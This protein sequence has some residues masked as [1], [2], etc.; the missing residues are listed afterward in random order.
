MPTFNIIATAT[1]TS[2]PATI[3]FSSIPSTYTDLC[4]LLC[5]RG[6]YGSWGGGEVR[7]NGSTSGTYIQLAGYN[8]TTSNGIYRADLIDEVIYSISGN[9]TNA[10]GT[11]QIY[12]PNYTSSNT[13]F[14]GAET[15]RSDMNSNN[16]GQRIVAGNSNQTS[17]VTSITI[18]DP[19]DDGFATNSTAY[20]Y[21]ISNA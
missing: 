11:T 12:I 14:I 20:L 7:L 19:T 4:I 13:K 8:S 5:V 6:Q 2:G 18:N 9:T 15:V 17:A 1:V 21:G 10:F 16:A 3:T